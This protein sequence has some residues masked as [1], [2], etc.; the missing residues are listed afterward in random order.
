MTH[1]LVNRIATLAIRGNSSTR[2]ATVVGSKLISTTS[3][4]SNIRSFTQIA[5]NTNNSLLQINYN[6]QQSS[7]ESIIKSR[8][9]SSYPKPLDDAEFVLATGPDGIQYN[10][11]LKP[12]GPYAKKRHAPKIKPGI[13]NRRIANLKNVSAAQKAIRHSPWR[14][15]L[16]CQFVAGQTVNDAMV[17]LKFVQKVKV[18][19][20]TDLIRN[21]ANTMKQKYGLLSSQIEIAECFATH[22]TH[23]ARVKTM[24]RGRSGRMHHR[25][26]HMRIVLREIDFPLKIMQA[27][28]LNQRNRWVERMRVAEEDAAK[29][30]EESVE[31]EELERQ[32]QEMQAKKKAE[33]KK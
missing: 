30:L 4:T 14:L 5:S 11:P 13:V 32:V 29:V 28:A 2:A 15:N 10:I 24:G 31:I 9:L 20:V 1:G 21:A 3:A 12:L 22:G 18:P 33:E 7:V 17:Q 25:F 23:L 27:T 26:S 6:N 16:I 8:S 19:L